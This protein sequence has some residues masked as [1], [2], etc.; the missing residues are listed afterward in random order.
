MKDKR[1]KFFT[2]YPYSN[3]RF[4]DPCNSCLVKP[5]CSKKN[6]DKL[7]DYQSTLH[8]KSDTII[9]AGIVSIFV[10]IGIISAV[11]YFK[12]GVLTSAIF[13]LSFYLILGHF[14]A[15]TNFDNR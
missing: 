14:I 9:L 3:F 11:L 4:R 13:T 2:I 8:T 10:L 12:V 1:N 7:S 5:C 15:S 6:C